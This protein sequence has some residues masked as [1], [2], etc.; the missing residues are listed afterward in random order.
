MSHMCRAAVQTMQAAGRSNRV[1]LL[2]NPPL[3]LRV[4]AQTTPDLSSTYQHSGETQSQPGF[5]KQIYILWALPV[6]L[7]PLAAT[8]T[9]GRRAVRP[10]LWG[11]V[12]L[13]HIP[14]SS[15]Q[16]CAECTQQAEPSTGL[17][18]QGPPAAWQ[19]T[20]SC[21]PPKAPQPQHSEA[22]N[23]RCLLTHPNLLHRYQGLFLHQL[24]VEGGWEDEDEHGCCRRT[25]KGHPQLRT[26][27]V[28]HSLVKPENSQHLNPQACLAQLTNE[29]KDVPN[30]R[31]KDDQQIGKHQDRHG[32]ENVPPPT[33][34]FGCTQ[35]V[36]YGAPDLKGG[37]RT[38]ARQEQSIPRNRART[39]HSTR[40]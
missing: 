17:G 32:D 13:D 39:C 34:V 26:R 8:S 7:P 20:A 21:L 3:P 24:D 29:T 36:S 10:L 4:G 6:P 23:C 2:P 38:L 5:W 1:T 30:R 18:L 40:R 15:P 27:G 11:R 35:Q 33:E 16:R 25:C 31:D 37:S 9:Q 22:H 14:M 19:N 28:T 12:S